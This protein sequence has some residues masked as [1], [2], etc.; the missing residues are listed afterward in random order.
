M[1][2]KRKKSSSSDLKW[3]LKSRSIQRDLDREHQQRDYINALKGT[4][5]T[6]REAIE[7]YKELSDL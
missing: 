4:N 3:E 6:T 7:R 5:Y 1:K 2:N